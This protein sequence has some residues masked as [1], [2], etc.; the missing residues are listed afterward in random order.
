[1]GARDRFVLFAYI[2]KCHIHR[3]IIQVKYSIYYALTMNINLIAKIIKY[4][5]D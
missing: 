2:H 4:Q 5:H 3:F 1:M